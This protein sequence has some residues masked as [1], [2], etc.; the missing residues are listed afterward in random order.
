MEKRDPIISK[1]DEKN[2]LTLL[3]ETRDPLKGILGFLHDHAKDRPVT[4]EEMK[5][6]VRAKAAEKYGGRKRS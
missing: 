5:A 2:R 3:P 4:V 6:D 1:P